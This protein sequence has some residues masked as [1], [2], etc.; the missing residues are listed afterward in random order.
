MHILCKANDFDFKKTHACDGWKAPSEYCWKRI[1]IKGCR[2]IFKIIYDNVLV[3]NM[4]Y[5]LTIPC[6]RWRAAFE[7]F[8]ELNWGRIISLRTGGFVARVSVT[9]TK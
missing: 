1:H 5:D 7:E 4:R 6:R 9:A 8:T 3:L 2:G